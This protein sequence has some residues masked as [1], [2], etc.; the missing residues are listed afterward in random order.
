MLPTYQPTCWVHHV[1]R[2]AKMPKCQKTKLLSLDKGDPYTESVFRSVKSERAVL[3]I[4]PSTLI[5]MRTALV[6]SIFIENEKKKTQKK[7]FK[8]K[9]KKTKEP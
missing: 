4:V 9:Q 6:A 5:S 1:L 7:N 8:Q 3:I 2:R